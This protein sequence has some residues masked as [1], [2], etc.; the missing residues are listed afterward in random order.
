MTG[1]TTDRAT[2][3]DALRTI[4]PS[5]GTAILDAL[6][7]AAGTLAVGER[8]RAIV[9]ITDGYDEHSQSAFDAAVGAFARAKSRVR[10]G[11]RGVAGISL[12]GEQLLSQL[13]SETGGRAWFPRDERQ[14]AL[15]YSTIASEVR[16]RY[17]LAYTPQ[18][19]VRDGRWRTISVN[20][21]QPGL[22]VRARRA[23]R[24]RW[25]R[26]SGLLSS[27]RPWKRT[28]AAR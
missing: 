6:A 1:P 23:T 16:H 4:R 5:G 27:S 26:R 21:H 9:L 24:R 8:R 22:K 25:R 19:Q 2:V 13:A 17:L 15:A 18:N 3:L 28:S 11:P 20:V 12:K 10:R 7:E 14:L